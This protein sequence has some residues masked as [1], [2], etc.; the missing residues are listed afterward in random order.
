MN[1]AATATVLPLRPPLDDDAFEDP[2][3][4]EAGE[5]AFVETFEGLPAAAASPPTP[6][7]A[8]PADDALLAALLQRIVHQDHHAL[9]ALYDHAAARV[10][11]LVQRVLHNHALAEEVVE[12]TFWQAWRQA[13]RF[14]ATRGRP[15]TWLLAIARSRAIDALRREQRF[16]HDEL[17]EDDTLAEQAGSHAGAEAL[18]AVAQDRQRLHAA[19]VLL[20]A[21]DRQLVSLAFLR[22]LTHEEIA[23]QQALPL[24]TVKSLIRRALL[25]LRQH[26]EARHAHA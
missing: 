18:G 12:D 17:P 26:F 19:L 8:G 4:A 5:E 14:D 10:Y 22:G 9:E 21:R 11:G 25:Q 6:P 7:R 15:L 23:E 3:A 24:G 13:P 16:Q 2:E 1:G 20:P